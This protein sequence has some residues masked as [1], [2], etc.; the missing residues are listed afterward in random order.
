MIVKQDDL[1]IQATYCNN[2]SEYVLIQENN[3]FK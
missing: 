2:F 3:M 1:I